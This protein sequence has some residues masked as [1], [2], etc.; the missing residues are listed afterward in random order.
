[1][2]IC[3]FSKQSRCTLK[4]RVGDRV[5]TGARLQ[6]IGEPLVCAKP[7]SCDRFVQSPLDQQA[8][9]TGTSGGTSRSC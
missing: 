9:P 1:M 8:S 3:E 7:F 4:L 5:P 6:R 2:A